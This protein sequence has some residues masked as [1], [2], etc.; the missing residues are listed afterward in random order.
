MWSRS[1]GEVHFYHT[2]ASNI[3]RQGFQ[4]ELFRLIH[5]YLPRTNPGFERDSHEPLLVRQIQELSV[6]ML[7]KRGRHAALHWVGNTYLIYISQLQLSPIF[8]W[9]NFL[10]LFDS[11]FVTLIFTSQNYCFVFGWFFTNN[12]FDRR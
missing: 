6:P 1:I 3:N 4:V 7:H 10:T 9:K 5:V 8:N 11:S 2:F 12:S